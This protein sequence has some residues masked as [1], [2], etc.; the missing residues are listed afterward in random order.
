MSI[1]LALKFN[2]TLQLYKDMARIYDTRTNLIPEIGHRLKRSALA[3]KMF[4]K[5]IDCH[6]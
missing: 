2:D 4:R 6:L 5:I 1:S 3:Y